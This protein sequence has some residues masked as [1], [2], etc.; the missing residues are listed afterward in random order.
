MSSRPPANTA[1]ASAASAARPRRYLDPK[2]DLAFKRVFGDHVNLLKSFLNALLPLPDDAQI[3]SLEYLTPE[4]VPE[5]P[6]FKYSIVDVKCVDKKG[7]IFIVEMQMMWVVAFEQRLVFGASQAYIKQL[8]EGQSYSELRPVYALAI[9][10][11]SFL[12]ARSVAGS[13]GPADYYHHYKIVNVEHPQQTLKGLEFVIIELPK[14]RP[15]SRSE[16]RLQT[17]WLRFLRETGREPMQVI[18]AAL[19]ED[20]DIAEALNLV[21]Q[22]AFSEAELNGYHT[23]LDRTRMAVDLMADATAKGEAKGRT[24]GRTEGEAKGRAEGKAEG[25]A[26]GKAEGALAE[27]R[28][29]AAA[30]LAD[31]SSIE[32]VAALTGLTAQELTAL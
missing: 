18:D 15:E 20:Q 12:P 1:V 26:K 29:I 24:E 32:R 6:G 2:I 22:S 19:T 10:N 14:F 23:A 25:E 3:E 8:R 9:V 13:A 27:K 30:L 31:G 28:A 5:V 11:S 16:K 17:L 4:Q 21:E 7:R